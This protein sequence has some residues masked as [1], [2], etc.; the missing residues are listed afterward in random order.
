MRPTLLLAAVSLIGCAAAGQ[1][2]ERPAIGF[3]RWQEDWS[4][5][6]DPGLRT[7]PFDGLKYIPL[8]AN[9]L[10]SYLSFGLNLRERYEANDAAKFGTVGNGDQ[11]YLLQRAQIHADLHLDSHWQIFL[12]MEDDIQVGKSPA[13]PVDENPVN[14]RQAFVT[15]DTDLAGGD[16]KLRVGRQEM[17]FDLQ[18]FVSVRDGPN[19]RQA[20]DAVW[21]NWSD[22]HWRVIGFWSQPVQYR[23]T[24]AF[25]DV[26]NNRLQYG[27]FRVER[28]DIGPGSLSAYYSRYEADG[29]KFLDAAG[30]ERRDNFDARYAGNASGFD[31][32]V[33]EM[34]Q[35]GHV[36][37]TSILAW[38][39][40]SRSGYTLADVPW[41]PRLGLQADA[42]SGDQ[43]PKDGTLGTFN[44]LFPN[45]YYVTLSGYT[46]YTNFVHVKPSVTVK[47]GKSIT[48]MASTG[49][50]WRETTADAV[51]VQPNVAVAN[52]AGHGALW[53]GFYE[54]MRLDWAVTKNVAT[55][56]EA[57]HFQI[58]DSLR[59][60][61]GHD[62]D[63]LGVEIRFGW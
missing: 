58:G 6:G 51:Y 41:T 40:G 48:L 60:A 36:G 19:V 24:Q 57:V 45:G 16:L 7:E 9:D 21:S 37:A 35:T 3:N 44:P 39:F 62:S 28:N 11:H 8:A 26:S 25:D 32:D 53:T 59:A 50:L 33:E 22:D 4:V 5:L 52:T 63:Y 20:Y 1:E 12:Q 2:P 54:Q 61:G 56:V 14:I 23:D 30:D 15:Y 38:A 13:T 34:T 10:D 46:G 42:A 29:A 47:P 31:W 55:A 49:L 27:G 18:R 43:H 17:A